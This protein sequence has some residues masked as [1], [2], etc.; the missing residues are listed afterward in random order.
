MSW[1]LAQNPHVKLAVVC[2]S[3]YTA[4]KQRG[5]QLNTKTW[6]N[7]N[8]RPDRV[9]RSTREV[10]GIDFDYLVCSNKVT[11][12]DNSS[13][14]DELAAT[15]STN[16]VLVSVQ[17]GVDVEAPLRH[18]FPENPILSAICH[19]GCSQLVPG[20]IEQTV[21]ISPYAFHI[22]A[23]HTPKDRSAVYELALE[24]F[25]NLDASFKQIKDVPA[26]RWTKQ[27]FNGSWNLV[28]ALSGLETHALLASPH[29][30]TVLQ[31]AR[32]TFNVAERLGVSLPSDLPERTVELVTK[33]PSLAPSTLQDARRRMPM[34][35]DSLCG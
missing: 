28:A 25:S 20:V 13:I 6:G 18:A 1:R 30:S 21:S 7:G 12:G 10:S 19:I 31:L 23:Y 9:V 26:A 22:G 16:T 33:H 5:V 3:N 35:L 27:I 24:Q 11:M 29:L 32:E 2:R 8:F 17:N 15:I 14:V 34:E 4:I